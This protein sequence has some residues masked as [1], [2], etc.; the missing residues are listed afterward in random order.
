MS[1]PD[2]NYLKNIRNILVILLAIAVFV[3]LRNLSSLLLPL[4]L[5][6]LLTI[7]ALPL[8]NLLER[9]HLPRFLIT[10]VV[11]IVTLALIW[12]IFSMIHGTVQQIIVQHKVLAQQFSRKMNSVLMW[13]QSK[14][15][16]ID[17]NA[18]KAETGKMFSAEKISF[19]ITS[20]LGTI[21]NFGSSLFLFLFYY[22]IF[23]SGATSYTAYVDY[24][25]GNDGKA[26]TREIW[27]LTQESISSYMGIKTIISLVTGIL[28][29]LISWMFGLRFA[30][31]W[32]FLAFIL[33]FI[34]SI[35]SF[36]ATALPAFMAFVQFDSA[37]MV[38]GLV[39]LLGASQF[40]IG[41]VLD[42]M[43][44][45]S[46][47]SLNTVTVIF[48]LIFWGYIWGIPGMLLSVPLMV[49]VRLILE[50]S[51]DLSILARIMG[52]PGKKNRKKTDLY[53][54]LINRQ[55]NNSEKVEENEET[56]AK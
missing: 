41:S 56:S 51:E 31:F 10:I 32:G 42:P 46:R 36:A 37:G 45:G 53:T 17:I 18:F 15:P 39:L 50:R 40:I 52:N 49:M 16:G 26:E 28:A 35:G 23:L 30:L 8:V 54:R 9:I 11:A 48:G 34:P 12:A 1:Q 4:V 13:I 22:I 14:F 44:M 33:N 21:G 24:V 43:I 2:S 19:Y 38:I 6:G 27:L 5:A 29:G 7:L 25:T 55:K 47:L 3:L 20:A